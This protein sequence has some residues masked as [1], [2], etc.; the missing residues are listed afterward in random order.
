MVIPH[1]TRAWAALLY[2]MK[3]LFLVFT[4]L[5]FVFALLGFAVFGGSTA[6]VFKCLFFALFIL[7]LIA[8]FRRPK[9]TRP[10]PTTFAAAFAAESD[11]PASAFPNAPAA[12]APD[13]LP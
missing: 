7:A 12:A 10:V 3:Y 11:Q 6:T 1:F 8:M 5:S 13:P 4:A 9:V 2:A